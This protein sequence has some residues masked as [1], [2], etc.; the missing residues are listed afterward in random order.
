M[1]VV[2]ISGKRTCEIVER[3]DPSI[4]GD[5]VKIAI[6]S[7]PMCTEWHAY[8]DGATGDVLGHE[9]AGEV[10]EVAQPGRVAVGDRVVV[11]PQYGCGTCSLCLSGEHIHCR[12]PVDPYSFCGSKTGCATY[13]QFCIKQ[14]WLLVKIPGDIS[15]DHASMACCGLGPTFNAMQQMDVSPFD[16]VLVSGLGPVGLGAVVNARC[17]G[18]RVIALESNEYR[19]ALAKAIGVEAVVD[20]RDGHCLERIMELTAGR[21]ADK[22]VETSSAETAPGLL[23]HA[24]R[25]KGH[26]ASVGWGGP[27][28][29]RDIVARGLTVHGAWHWNHFRDSEAML[30]TIRQSRAILDKVITHVFAMRDVREAWELQLTGKCGKVIL[31]PWD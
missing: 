10:V 15:Y 17:R 11:M 13:A 23:V 6:R 30:A 27:M 3:P 4:K 2:S 5:F 9:A 24:T 25:H 12:Q 14:D 22:S 31:H 29:A 1:K 20:P 7:A 26:V 21:G 16:T 28:L 8:R 19:A 18:A